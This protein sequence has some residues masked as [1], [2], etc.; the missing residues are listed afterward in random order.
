MTSS[1]KTVFH[2]YT[3]DP[4]TVIPL[5]LCLRTITFLKTFSPVK[6]IC[7]FFCHCALI[8]LLLHSVVKSCVISLLPG[9]SAIFKAGTHMYSQYN[10]FAVDSPT[11][12]SLR[13]EHNLAQKYQVV[14][15]CSIYV[16]QHQP[17]WAKS[18]ANVSNNENRKE[19]TSAKSGYQP[20]G[21]V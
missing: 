12:L 1:V 10:D 7:S 18:N 5:F 20:D 21:P 9:E 15:A 13:R 14:M 4:G 2:L 8:V 3:L 6:E 16:W 17:A 19:S 11:S